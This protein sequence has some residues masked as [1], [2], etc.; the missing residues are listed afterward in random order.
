MINDKS[1]KTGMKLVELSYL[2]TELSSQ[3]TYFSTMRTAFALAVVAAYT[4]KW[5]ILLF[6][7][8]LLIGGYS[9]YYMLG[10]ILK[11]INEKQEYENDKEE[12]NKYY[13]LYKLRENNN[14]ILLFYCLIFGIAVTLEFMT[15][16]RIG[17]RYILRNK[18][19][20]K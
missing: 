14:K 3:N 4:Q 15:E 5:F 1:V 9:Q 11:N 17:G 19:N 16:K 2:R 10:D 8:I 20:K 12:R 7:I 18:F 6:S 13:E